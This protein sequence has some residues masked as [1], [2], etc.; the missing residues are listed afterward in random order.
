M[1]SGCQD[2]TSAVIHIPSEQQVDGAPDALFGIVGG[3]VAPLNLEL[4]HAASSCSA[5]A[6][7]MSSAFLFASSAFSAGCSTIDA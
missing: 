3:L 1:S 5:I 4:P 2:A 6:R 7:M